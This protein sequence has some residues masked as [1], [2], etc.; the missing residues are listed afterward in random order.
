MWFK[1]GFAAVALILLTFSIPGSP[2]LKKSKMALAQVKTTS[3]FYWYTHIDPLLNRIKKKSQPAL[4]KILSSMS[5]R[6]SNPPTHVLIDGEWYEKSPDNRYHINGEVIFF[7]EEKRSPAS[8]L[9][10]MA[11][12]QES[13]DLKKTAHPLEETKNGN[14]PQPKMDLKQTIE[15]SNERNRVLHQILEDK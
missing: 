6:D 13:A 15:K 2:I 1:L 10:K 5:E 9:K 4:A 3:R 8:L 14:N 11:T 12:E 7:K